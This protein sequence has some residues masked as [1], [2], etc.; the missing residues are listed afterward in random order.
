MI[1]VFV[2]CVHIMKK[3]LLIYERSTI[4]EGYCYQFVS[5]CLSVHRFAL[6]AQKL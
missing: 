4:G 1:L 2:D 5:V 3:L 6:I